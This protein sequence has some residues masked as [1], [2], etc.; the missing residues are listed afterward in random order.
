MKEGDLETSR[1]CDECMQLAWKEE[2][3]RRVLLPLSKSIDRK[4]LAAEAGE[5]ET[6]PEPEPIVKRRRLVLRDYQ[7]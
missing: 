2:Y 6:E 4:A 7:N 5:K 3:R 1:I